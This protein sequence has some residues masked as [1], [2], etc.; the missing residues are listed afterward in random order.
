MVKTVPRPLPMQALQKD[1]MA[2]AYSEIGMKG[3]VCI[4]FLTPKDWVV[5]L[6][7][8]CSQGDPHE[9]PDPPAVGPV[10]IPPGIAGRSRAATGRGKG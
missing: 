3:E 2:E 7:C 10:P 8:G 6:G 5:A 1:K 4:A 9:L